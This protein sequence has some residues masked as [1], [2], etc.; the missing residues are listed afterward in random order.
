MRVVDAKDNYTGEHSQA[1]SDLVQGIARRLGL[2]GAD[3]RAAAPRR[4]AARPRQGRDPGQHPAEARGARRRG[5]DRAARASRDRLPAARGRRRRA[6]ARVGAPPPRGVGRLRLPAR[7]GRRRDPA[8]LA[9]HPGRRR[10]PRDDVGA[11]VPEGPLHE[12]RAGRA[13]PLLAGRS[14][15]R[16]SSRRSRST[17]PSRPASRPRRAD[18]PASSPCCSASLVGLRARRQAV[19]AGRP[20]AARHAAVRRGD[21]A[22]GAR[23]PVRRSC[24]GGVRHRRDGAVARHLRP[25]DRDRRA[26]PPRHR[27]SS[28]AGAGMASNLR[29]D[30]RERRS[31]A[32]AAAARCAAPA[33][34]STASS[35]TASPTPSRTSRGWSTAGRRRRGCR[36]RTST[37]SATCC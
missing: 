28:I 7:P 2:D 29:R 22:A 3:D 23:V 14:S 1:V 32:G 36:A 35:T 11:A 33:S 8:R 4:P 30:P 34:R 18:G 15:T 26:E 21:R 10:V 16:A 27:A 37:R 6:R 19:G 25:A 13:P 31:H 24:R 5:A 9:D 20:A 12:R 17:W